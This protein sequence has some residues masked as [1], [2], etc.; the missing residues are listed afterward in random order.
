MPIE[1]C[2]KCGS[3]NLRRFSDFRHLRKRNGEKEVVWVVGCNECD[4]DMID[5][6][7]MQ[8]HV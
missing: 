7:E 3:T 1:K 4:W 8:H 2:D 6:E 5:E